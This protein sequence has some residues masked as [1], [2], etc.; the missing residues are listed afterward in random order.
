MLKH[1]RRYYN[2]LS[3]SLVKACEVKQVPPDILLGN[4]CVKIIG[5]DAFSRKRELKSMRCLES[6]I[7]FKDLVG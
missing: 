2:S 3:L 5:E 4:S 6:N 1:L 7:T